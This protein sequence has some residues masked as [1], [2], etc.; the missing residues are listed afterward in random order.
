M[1]YRHRRRLN[2]PRTCRC[3]H[4]ARPQVGASG[5][6][7]TRCKLCT[8]HRTA[9][10]DRLVE[11]VLDVERQAKYLPIDADLAAHPL[12]RHYRR[13][14]RFAWRASFPWTT[15][16][17]L[18]LDAHYTRGWKPRSSTSVRAGQPRFSDACQT[19][20]APL[21]DGRGVSIKIP[22]LDE[23]TAC[24]EHRAQAFAD[25]QALLEAKYPQTQWSI[26]GSLV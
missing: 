24:P 9:L 6:S 22:R 16:A 7:S 15:T 4:P 12:A 25:A 19:C 23:I 26:T 17:A 21:A 8:R 5:T 18:T 10:A 2:P 20:A 14:L 3:E 13:L 1:G 11:A